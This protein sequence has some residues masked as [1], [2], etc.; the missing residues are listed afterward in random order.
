MFL[1]GW[2]RSPRGVLGLL[3]TQRFAGG[4]VGVGE[5]LGREK[6]YAQVPSWPSRA[7]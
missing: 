3:A 6:W 7:S 4:G 1:S 2:G 5:T